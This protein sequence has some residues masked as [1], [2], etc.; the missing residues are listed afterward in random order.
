M[1]HRIAALFIWA[2]LGLAATL[3]LA[4]CGP[5]GTPPPPPTTATVLTEGSFPCP[6]CTLA[7]KCEGEMGFTYEPVNLTGEQ[8]FD[9]TVY[10]PALTVNEIPSGGPPDGYRC[11]ANWT[12]SGLKAGEWRITISGGINATCNATLNNGFGNFV[13]FRQGQGGCKVGF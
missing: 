10:S 9:T 2:V 8:G 6:G 13:S 4:Q 5:G 3:A 11:T 7:T 12:Q 1:L